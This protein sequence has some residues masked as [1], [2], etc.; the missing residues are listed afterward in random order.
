MVCLTFLRAGKTLPQY[1][2]G[3]VGARNRAAQTQ[4]TCKRS[5]TCVPSGIRA[6]LHVCFTFLRAGKHI[7]NARLVLSGPGKV[8]L[9]PRGLLSAVRHACPPGFG[10]GFRQT[11]ATWLVPTEW[12][13]PRTLP[14]LSDPEPSRFLPTHQILLVGLESLPISPDSCPIVANCLTA[15]VPAGRSFGIFSL[16]HLPHLSLIAALFARPSPRFY[17]SGVSI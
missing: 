5:P 10:V 7:Q 16:N 12:R 14:K 3:V 11:R 8:L 1:A 6:R 9:R 2:T 4:R 13:A 17:R 15:L